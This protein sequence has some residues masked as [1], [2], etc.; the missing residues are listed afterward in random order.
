MTR[1][2]EIVLNPTV[3]SVSGAVNGVGYT[4]EAMKPPAML[5][6]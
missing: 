2:V 5:V 4:L 1:S 6:E 3:V